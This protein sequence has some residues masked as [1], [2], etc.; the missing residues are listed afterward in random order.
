MKSTLLMTSALLLTAC[1]GPDYWDRK[2]P[3]QREV[4]N[5]PAAALS[6][7]VS[8]AQGGRPISREPGSNIYIIKIIGGGAVQSEMARAVF[9]GLGGRTEVTTY[10]I[11]PAFRDMPIY[12][13]EFI[14]A[15]RSCSKR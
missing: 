10:G 11:T 12:S 5:R 8:Q 15:A 7:C 14:D 2:E 1:V 4:F 3:W 13:T 9:R 6:Q